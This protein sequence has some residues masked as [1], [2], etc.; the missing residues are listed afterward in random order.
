M[1][2]V[3]QT[4]NPFLSVVYN[5][6]RQYCADLAVWKAYTSSLLVKA[7]EERKRC[8]EILRQ[9]ADVAPPQVRSELLLL[10]AQIECSR[11]QSTL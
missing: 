6:S 7:I 3:A 5:P 11:G 1:S 8:V 2:L 10:I 9:R 4:Y